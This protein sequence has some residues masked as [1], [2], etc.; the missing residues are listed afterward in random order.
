M[1]G[2]FYCLVTPSYQLALPF[3][4]ILEFLGAIVYFTIVQRY[5]INGREQKYIETR[6]NSILK[7]DYIRHSTSAGLFYAKGLTFHLVASV[8]FGGS[9][10]LLPV[11]VHPATSVA[12]KKLLAA[13]TMV[14]INA[15][16]PWLG[17]ALGW[18]LTHYGTV[19]LLLWLTLFL[20]IGITLVFRPNVRHRIPEVLAL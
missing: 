18:G 12:A 4:P 13:E 10:L 7:G 15:S 11:L 19:I 2:W 16:H 17:Q 1:A 9:L 8:I 3:F 5:I 6:M 20:L 14:T